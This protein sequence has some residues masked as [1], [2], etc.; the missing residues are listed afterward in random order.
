MLPVLV[1]KLNNLP[2]SAAILGIFIVH[3]FFFLQHNNEKVSFSDT[4][5]IKQN[6]QEFDLTARKQEWTFKI[7]FRCCN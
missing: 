2:F 5:G 3:F 7:K 1:T 4:D 6:V